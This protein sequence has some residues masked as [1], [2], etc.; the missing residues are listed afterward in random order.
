MFLRSEGAKARE[1]RAEQAQA[2]A[3]DT[4]REWGAVEKLC[5]QKRTKQPNRVA[6]FVLW[7]RHSRFAQGFRRAKRKK[8]V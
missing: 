1:R 3:H 8:S 4:R 6:F 2:I 7:R 5:I